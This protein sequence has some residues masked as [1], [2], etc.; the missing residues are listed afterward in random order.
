MDIRKSG[1]GK[2]RIIAVVVTYNRCAMLER[3]LAALREQSVPCDVLIVDNASTDG[4]Q[5]V[6]AAHR[7]EW[8]FSLRM[9]ENLGGA[10]G[11]NAGLRWGAE[12]GYD[13]LWV[14]DDDTLPTP[15]ALEGLLWADRELEGDYGF[16]ASTALWTDGSICRMNRLHAVEKLCRPEQT[17]KGLWRIRQATFV[18]CFFRAET[19]RQYGLPIREFFI[20]GDDIEF[21]RRIAVRGGEKCYWVQRSR[22]I[23]AMASNNGSCLATDGGE[24]IPRYNYAYRNENYLFRQEGARGMCRYVLRCGKHALMILL[25]AP[26]HRCK[27]LWIIIHQ[28][29]AGF[30]FNPKVEKL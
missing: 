17:D 26:D 12:H 21:T 19:I 16:L 4:T 5:R 30:A 25:R 22:V 2:M 7:S 13:R 27:R 20:W 28:F 1:G 3:C 10:G 29:F 6:V 18:S 14:M 11:F 24:R 9:D 15:G 8:C 23:H